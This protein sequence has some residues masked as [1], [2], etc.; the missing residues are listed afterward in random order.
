[1]VPVRPRHSPPRPATAT[2]LMHTL[3]M[4]VSGLLDEPARL[5]ALLAEVKGFVRTDAGLDLGT[6]YAIARNMAKIVPGSV[7]FSTVPTRPHPDDPN[8]L[9]W[10]RAA[11]ER[12]FAGI[13]RDAG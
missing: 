4:R 11:A 9:V 2:K 10:D 7:T 12:L 3:V 13:R 6:M 5:S 1:M 8:R